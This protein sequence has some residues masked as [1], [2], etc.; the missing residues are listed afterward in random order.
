MSLQNFTRAAALFIVASGCAAPLCHAARQNLVANGG[1]EIVASDNPAHPA[2]WS[3]DGKA[4]AYAIDRSVRRSGNQSMRV[5][6]K[7][8]TNDVGY[9][10]VLAQ[11][12]PKVLLGQRIVLEGYFRRTSAQSRVGLWLMIADNDG[13]RLAYVNT[14]DSAF[15]ILDGWAKQR[16]EVDVPQNAARLKFGAAIYERDGTMWVDDISLRT[17]SR[18]SDKNPSKKNVPASIN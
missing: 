3:E 11:L 4:P 8:G 12:E 18:S 13:H 17:L 1:F 10:G 14:Y 15:R 2:D 9:S 5:A 6:F 7:D 16:L